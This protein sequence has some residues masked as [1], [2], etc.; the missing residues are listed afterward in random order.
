MFPDLL[1]GNTEKKIALNWIAL[2]LYYTVKM[3]Y[4]NKNNEY[5]MTECFSF[6]HI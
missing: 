6:Q 4:R 3:T 1:Y 5:V 2:G